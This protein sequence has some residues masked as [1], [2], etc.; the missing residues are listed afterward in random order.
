MLFRSGT[1]AET[2]DGTEADTAVLHGRAFD[3]E[4]GDG[5]DGFGSHGRVE[6]LELEQIE[7]RQS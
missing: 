4:G 7:M 6:L 1:D 5:D 3:I 2:R